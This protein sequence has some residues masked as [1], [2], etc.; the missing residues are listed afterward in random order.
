MAATVFLVHYICFNSIIPNSISLLNASHF[1]FSLFWFTMFDFSATLAPYQKLH[2]P[3]GTLPIHCLTCYIITLQCDVTWMQ[4]F[5][6]LFTSSAYINDSSGRTKV[7]EIV[8]GHCYKFYLFYVSFEYVNNSIL[9]HHCRIRPNR[10]YQVVNFPQM[11]FSHHHSCMSYRSVLVRI[12]RF[13]YSNT[14]P[15]TF[16][17]ILFGVV[18]S[19]P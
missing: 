10:V 5:W 8:V 18:M 14:V 3:Q 19:V 15:L 7:D 16:C 2:F 4:M 17:G 9:L 6:P 12:C 11:S 1:F 13:S